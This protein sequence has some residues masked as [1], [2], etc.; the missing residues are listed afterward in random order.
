MVSFETPT[1]LMHNRGL[2]SDPEAF[3]QERHAASWLYL[4][5]EEFASME[6]GMSYADVER[7]VPVAANVVSDP[8]TPLDLD[9]ARRQI[10]ALDDLPRPTL[11][12]CRTGPRSSA[13]IYL[14]AGLR[15]SA[16]AEDVIA[17]AEA[18]DAPFVRSDELRAWV[19]EGLT[20]LA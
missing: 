19:T 1:D 13:L 7:A 8:P 17:R 20:Q 10:E 18:D 14:Y 6:G 4:C 11:V 15:S 9:L 3:A 5:G 12:T 16:S 2:V